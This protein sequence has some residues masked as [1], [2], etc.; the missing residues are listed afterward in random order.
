MFDNSLPDTEDRKIA[1]KVRTFFVK[2]KKLFGGMGNSE[3]ISK[4]R[5]RIQR[6][7]RTSVGVFFRGAS[8]NIKLL[9]LQ[10]LQSFE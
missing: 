3:R 6:G 5:K 10:V 1:Q 4:C 2:T 9:S 8:F 7:I